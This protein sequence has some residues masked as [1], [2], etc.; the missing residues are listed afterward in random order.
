MTKTPKTSK[1]DPVG[2]AIV[3]VKTQKG[4]WEVRLHTYGDPEPIFGYAMPDDIIVTDK[5]VF[6]RW[7]DGGYTLVPIHSVIK[8]H[9]EPVTIH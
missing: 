9:Y 4:M 8:F 5:A 6:I 3:P 1:K 2:T 7:L